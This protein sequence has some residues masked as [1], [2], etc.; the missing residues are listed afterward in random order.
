MGLVTPK[1][2]PL[3]KDDEEEWDINFFKDT[4]GRW[5]TVSL[6]VEF[7]PDDKYPAVYTI[8]EQDKEVD[9]KDY[10]S[11][12]RK[13]FEYSDPTEF[14]FATKAFGSYECWEAVVASPTVRPYVEQWRKE[15][16]LK[17][18][19]EGIEALKKRLGTDINAEKWFADE[20]WKAVTSKRGRP[21]K[22]KTD[23]IAQ[24]HK[25]AAARMG[26]KAVK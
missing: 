14:I 20:K 3:P 8:H 11:L 1:W 26:I 9:G 22:K 5:R 10:I 16:D 25:D 13:Y 15:L 21:S 4:G 23:Q 17:L 2:T 6:F 12:K 7:N 19:A 24:E 18:K